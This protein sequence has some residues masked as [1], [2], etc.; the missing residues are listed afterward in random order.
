MS[1]HRVATIDIGTVSTRLFIGDITAKGI[2]PLVR[3]AQITDLGQ[4][5]A[6]S[7]CLIDEAMDRTV[8][9][10]EEYTQIIRN[11]EGV[12]A[13]VCTLTSAARDAENVEVLLD[14]LRVLGLAPQVI[15]GDIEAR[16]TFLGVA[17]EFLNERIMVVD[18]GGGST[19]VVVG[20][21][22]SDKDGQELDL[23]SVR[24]FDIGCRR[25]SELFQRHD[26]PLM[27]DMDNAREWI[28][29]EFGS[30][31]F[32]IERVDRMV[33]VGG[34]PTSLVAVEKELDP[35]DSSQV[36]MV[37]LTGGSV[38]DLI[39]KLA[40]LTELERAQLPGLQEK[41]APVI[42]SGAL[43]LETLLALGGFSSVTVSESDILFGLSAV[44]ADTLNGQPSSFSW[45]PEI[46]GV[47]SL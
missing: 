20:T 35:Y 37:E 45:R 47:E 46:S 13:V 5:R 28:A 3:E 10:V 4:G 31:F 26:P 44:C 34:T 22:S 17:Q 9:A 42:V 11:V 2:F 14:R 43:I 16:L 36:H 23:E 6:V 27:G 30:H 24:S 8:A 32:D 1:D 15:P 19:E 12:E 33:A 7:S 29:E 39:D 41:R 21:F 38:A 25:V 40:E 18:I